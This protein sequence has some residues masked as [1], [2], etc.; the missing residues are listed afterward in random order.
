M[1]GRG[2]VILSPSKAN[3]GTLMGT[4][5]SSIHGLLSVVCQSRLR[6]TNPVE[7]ESGVVW[8]R[9]SGWLL[10]AFDLPDAALDAYTQHT[11][12]GPASCVGGGLSA[13]SYRR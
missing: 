12:V 2:V 3:S 9:T 10:G 1:S 13:L 6:K 11:D 8:V 7:P 5:H 4:D